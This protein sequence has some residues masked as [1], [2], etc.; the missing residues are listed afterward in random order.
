MIEN[1]IVLWIACLVF[2]VPLKHRSKYPQRVAAAFLVACF[3]LEL[4]K[5]I[6]VPVEW[7]GG[8]IAV[9]LGVRLVLCAAFIWFCGAVSLSSAVYCAMWVMIICQAGYEIQYVLYTV[10]GLTTGSL[11]TAWKVVVYILVL[12]ILG[13]TVAWTLP[14]KGRYHIGPR[15]MSSALALITLFECLF[16]FLLKLSMFGAEKTKY[17][18]IVILMQGNC[19]LVIHLQNALFKKSAMKQEFETLNRL[20]HQQKEQYELAEE[21][22]TLIN[23]KC[24][25]LKHQIAAMRMMDNPEQQKEYIRQIEDS[26][27][28]Y[29]SMVKTKC[30]AFDTIMTEKSLQCAASKIKI[31]CI[32]D[33]HCMEM[34]EPV[35]LYTIFGNALDNAIEYVKTLDQPEMRI[36][37]VHVYKRRQFLLIHVMNPLQEQL[38]FEDEIPV[39]TKPKNGYHGYGI[40]SIIHTVEKYNGFAKIETC[41]HVFSL[42]IMIPATQSE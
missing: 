17:L 11:F 18:L 42:D 13:S 6:E 24:H 34:I 14:E 2:L 16:A 39:S 9:S 10:L 28:I 41:N 40:K 3:L 12:G 36:I 29:D 33:G 37:D 38:N 20:W 8:Q 23:H 4:L 15:Q 21:T 26:V 19:V 5:M 1:N 27:Q 35:D 31:N 7:M 30:K 25:D 22:V 32:A